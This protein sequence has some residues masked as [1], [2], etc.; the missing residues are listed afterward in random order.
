[1]WKEYL[2]DSMGFS[3]MPILDIHAPHGSCPFVRNAKPVY[4]TEKTGQVQRVCVRVCVCVRGGGGLI[5]FTCQ[6]EIK[7]YGSVVFPAV[8]TRACTV[9]LVARGPTHWLQPPV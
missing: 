6:T 1:M 4:R 9:V 3:T 5:R 8:Q 2:P 7:M